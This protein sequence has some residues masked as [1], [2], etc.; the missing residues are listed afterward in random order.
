MPFDP[1]YAKQRLESLK[2]SLPQ[3]CTWCKREKPLKKKS[4]LCDS[5]DS[6]RREI[7]KLQK[8]GASPLERELKI[9]EYMK[10]LCIHWGERFEDT[11]DGV[12]D[13]SSLEHYFRDVAAKF[14]GDWHMHFKKEYM[15]EDLLTPEQVAVIEYLFWEPL[16][17]DASR[18]RR[19]VAT[20]RF[21]K[22]HFTDS[23]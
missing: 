10:E 9:A 18:N 23:G 17:E 22:E 19:R 15:L 16:S 7:D 12:S 8:Q 21:D 1:A 13:C 5:C 11:L 2:Q 14:A 6:V 20:A 4:R 3:R